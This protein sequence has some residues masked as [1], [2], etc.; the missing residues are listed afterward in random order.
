[1]TIAI[2]CILLAALLPLACAGLAKSRG[3]KVSHRD[4]GYDNRSPRDWIAKQEG[5][6]RWANAAQENSW[7]AFPFFAAAVIVSHML[8]VTGALPDALAVAF[9]VLRSVYVW[10]YVT[11]RQKWRS[12][13]W[14][15]AWLINV[16]IF[17]LPLFR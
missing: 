4:G 8:G 11:A 10:C 15:L 13:V 2:F 1:M 14:A 5:F 3:F 7:E 9:I 12:R 17:L 16:T 6:S